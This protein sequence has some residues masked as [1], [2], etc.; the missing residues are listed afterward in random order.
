[1][2]EN[3]FNDSFIISQGP[4]IQFLLNKVTNYISKSPVTFISCRTNGNALLQ[5]YNLK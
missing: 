1:V 2:E 5:K 3:S 4:S